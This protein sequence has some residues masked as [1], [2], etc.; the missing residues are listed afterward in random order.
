MPEL[1]EVETVRRDL[2]K[3]LIGASFSQIKILDFKN[4]APK[5]T[6]LASF[7]KK[8]EI[9]NISRKGKLLIFNLRDNKYHLL[10][11]LKMTGQMVLKRG[12]ESFAGGHSLSEQSFNKAI[13]GS[14]P[15]KFSRAIFKFVNG[16][17]L[18]FNDID[19]KSVV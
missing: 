9:M 4:V 18:F 3:Y 17:I 14:L 1:P 13:G 5:A 10:F 19:R 8:K 7:L 15:N 16:D 12:K 11:H 6:F 2:A